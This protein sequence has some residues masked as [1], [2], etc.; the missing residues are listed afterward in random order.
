MRN[1]GFSL[2]ELM[3]TLTIV[4]I[5]LAIGAP[6]M[7]SFLKN[8]RVRSQIANLTSDINLARSE[9]VRAK[10][11][12][13]LCR[14]A[15]PTAAAPSC[16]G[17][18]NT[19]TTGW[20]IFASGDTNNT[21]QNSTDRLLRI[22]ETVN[23]TDLL[24]RTNSTSNQNLE[25]NGDGSTNEGGGTA[26]FAVCDARGGDHGRQI[27]VPPHGRMRIVKGSGS[28]PINCNSPV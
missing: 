12:V 10:R 24:V 5:A 20:L 8:N 19:W 27:N 3:A 7:Q 26:R 21:F 4:A 23:A 17:S 13:I 6:A 16:G 25:F 11:R 2:P 9:A 1:R 14:S 18:S 22:R 15:N 28:A